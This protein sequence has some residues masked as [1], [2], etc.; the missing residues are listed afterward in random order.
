MKN[1]KDEITYN[2]RTSGT[3]DMNFKWKS[4]WGF[5]IDMNERL[6]IWFETPDP[7]YKNGKNFKS[8]MKPKN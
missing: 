6:K 7:F 5:P 4:D 8:R 2:T 3:Q 1:E